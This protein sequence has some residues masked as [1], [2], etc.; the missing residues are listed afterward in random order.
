MRKATALACW[1]VVVIVFTSLVMQ[2]GAAPESSVATVT[3]ATTPALDPDGVT[4]ASADA[5]AAVQL[6]VWVAGEQAAAAEAQ[7]VADE[8]AAAAEKAREDSERS[9]HTTSVSPPP[10]ASSSWERFAAC[11]IAHE[12]GGDPTVYN[13][14]GSGASGLFQDMPG[15][16]G[17]YGGYANAA[18]APVAVQY[19]RNYE[20]WNGGAGAGNWVGSGC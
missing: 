9:V 8:A 10:V 2:S 11:V 15:T 16:W 3:T 12:S 1:V 20:I 5:S 17:G 14:G 13:A 4:L 6:L 19:A 18:D 7:R